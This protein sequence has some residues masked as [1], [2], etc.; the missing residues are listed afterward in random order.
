MAAFH[1]LLNN[2]SSW[3]NV[4]VCKRIEMTI[5]ETSTINEPCGISPNLDHVKLTIL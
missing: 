4:S 1:E 3:L 5:P 2:S